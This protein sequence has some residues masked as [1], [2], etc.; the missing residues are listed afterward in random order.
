M[1]AWSDED[2]TCTS[3]VLLV[4]CCR[5]FTRKLRVADRN[6]YAIIDGPYGSNRLQSLSRYDKVLFLADGIG[7]ATHLLPIR[8]LLRA[9]EDQTARVRR[10]TLVWLLETEG[11]L[12]FTVHLT[13][14]SSYRPAMLG[15]RFPRRFARYGSSPHLEYSPSLAESQR[16]FIARS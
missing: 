16:G 14:L 6:N 5:G 9:H 11:I 13:R 3:I 15:R 8:H 4:R 2:E 1:I 10:L 12:S 7:I